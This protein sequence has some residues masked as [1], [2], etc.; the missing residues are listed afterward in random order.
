MVCVKDFV[1]SSMEF[2]DTLLIFNFD[3]RMIENAKVNRDF[4]TFLH[5][6]L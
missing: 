4:K 6:N 5:G 3:E 1:G 2:V